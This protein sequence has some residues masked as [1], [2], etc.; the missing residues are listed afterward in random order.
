MS[1][2]LKQ[3]FLTFAIFLVLDAIWLGTIAPGF[4]QSQIGFLMAKNPIWAAA[5]F[6]YLLFVV[7]LVVFVVSP[8]VQQSSLRVAVLKGALFGLVTYATY[9]LTNLA[10]IE[11]WPVLV[12]AVDL[13][14]GSFLST[15]TATVSA[16]LL[17]RKRKA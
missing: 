7:G 9:D 8:A 14:W 12:T 3:Y 17:L 1:T 11:G 16:W 6:F 15:A 4:Y 10:T 2:F 13:V 5:G